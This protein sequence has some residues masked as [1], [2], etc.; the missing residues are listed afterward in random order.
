MP[1]DLV[2]Q[3]MIDALAQP[4]RPGRHI[5]YVGTSIGIALYPGDG[6]DAEALLSHA[7]AALHQAKAQGRGTLRFFSP[8]MTSRAKHRLTLDA[9]LRAALERQELRLH[10]QPQVDLISGEIV[11]LEAL[12]RWQHPERG[13]IAP[14]EFIPLAEESGLVVQLGDWVLHEACRQIRRWLEAGSSRA[15]R[16]SMSRRS[17]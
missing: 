5:V 15:R 16:R 17:S 13:M 11:G 8:E 3:R 7:D 1:T 10:Y 4:F 12:V 6:T 9:E 2:A 14:A